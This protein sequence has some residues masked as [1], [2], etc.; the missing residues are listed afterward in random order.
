MVFWTSGK[1]DKE[2]IKFTAEEDI[3]IEEYLLPYVKKALIL[4]A[5]NLRENDILSEQELKDIKDIIKRIKVSLTVEKEDSHTALFEAIK[6]KNSQLANKLRAYKSRNEEIAVAESF[7]FI[8][9]LNHLKKSLAELISQYQKLATKYENLPFIGFTH[10][11]IATVGKL[12]D[13]INSYTMI[14]DLE[15]EQINSLIKKIKLVSLGS[16]PGYGIYNAHE[17]KKYQIKHTDGLININNPQVMQHIRVYKHLLVS[18]FCLNLSFII[19]RFASDIIFFSSDNNDY[20]RLSKR[21]AQGSSAMPHKLNP[22]VFEI[23]RANH[24]KFE[25]YVNLCSAQNH[26]ISGYHRDYQISKEASV[27]A[28]LMIQREVRI[29]V[30]ALSEISF[31][32]QKINNDIKKYPELNSFQL[33]SKKA[34]KGNDVS[35]LY[36]KMRK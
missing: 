1:I 2:F 19:S 34:K 32:S 13:W 33:L 26:L 5:K 18:Q 28:I 31:N 3:K 15:K 6:E 8:E 25:N 27:K 23:L 9:N 14:I 29:L 7:F 21:I 22:D 17:R 20:I 11:K 4:H 30:K 36:E 24:S 10:T 16:G 35:K 12:P